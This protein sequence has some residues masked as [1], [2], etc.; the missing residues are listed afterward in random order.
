MTT[1]I[2]TPSTVTGR[3]VEYC[4]RE[5]V[6][7]SA[8]GSDQGV[9]EIVVLLDVSEDA[10]EGHESLRADL[11]GAAMYCDGTCESRARRTIGDMPLDDVTL[12]DTP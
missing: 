10:C 7:Q 2:P 5:G 6:I 9:H 12:L 4:D 3:R 11:M 8:Y 1:A